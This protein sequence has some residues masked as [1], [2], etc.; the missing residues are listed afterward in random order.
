MNELPRVRPY[1]SIEA[2]SATGPIGRKL[3]AAFLATLMASAMIVWYA[4]M[5]ELQQAGFHYA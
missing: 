2:R 1:S 3:A 5:L 4:T